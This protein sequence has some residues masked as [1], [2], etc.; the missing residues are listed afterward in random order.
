M[1]EVEQKR[2]RVVTGRVIS[3]KSNQTI[4]VLIERREPHPVYG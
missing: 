4:P 3:T 1:A 2:G